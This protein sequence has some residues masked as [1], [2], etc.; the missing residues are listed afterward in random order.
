[1]SFEVSNTTKQGTLLM[2]ILLYLYR[3][4]LVRRRSTS[5]YL[6]RR[7]WNS[8]QWMD[9]IVT[10]RKQVGQVIESEGSLLESIHFIR[11]SMFIRI[12]RELLKSHH[13]KVFIYSIMWFCFLADL[14]GTKEKSTKTRS[15]YL[16]S[17]DVKA[18]NYKFDRNINF[19]MLRSL[20]E[21]IQQI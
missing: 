2:F 12:S 13:L 8:C 7:Q 14:E 15:R 3:R 4:S 6:E 9:R 11:R 17:C 18:N 16:E 1:M 20:V 5:W 10:R 19:N 21:T